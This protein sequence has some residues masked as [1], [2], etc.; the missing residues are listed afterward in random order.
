MSC[1]ILQPYYGTPLRKVVVENEYLHPDAICPANSDDTM[2]DLPN[3]SADEMKGLRR[4]FAMYVK[5]PKNRWK[6]IEKAEKIDSEG[7]KVWEDLKQ[8]YLDR[9]L[10]T[11]DTDITEQGNPKDVEDS[12]GGMGPSTSFSI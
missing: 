1:S 6:D 12:Q 5:F 8:E 7:D 10:V 4:T 2:L 11:S 9:Y 3:Y